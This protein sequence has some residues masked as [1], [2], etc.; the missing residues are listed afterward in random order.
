MANIAHSASTHP[1]PTVSTALPIQQTT[2]RRWDLPPRLLWALP[3]A[4][5]SLRMLPFLWTFILPAP[6]GQ[7]VLQA[8]YM[9]PDV[10]SYQAFIRQASETSSVLLSNPYT[11]DPQQGRYILLLHSSLGVCSQA[12]GIPATW[13]WELSRFPLSCLFF[14]ALWWFLKPILPERSDRIWACLLVGL[15]GGVEGLLKLVAD[16]LPE[17]FAESF[18]QAT[19]H[20]YGWNTFE[21]LANPMWIAGLTLLLV[22]LKPLLQPDGLR[23]WC[24]QCQV[25]VGFLILFY[26]HPYSGLVVLAVAGALAIT[27]AIF[28]GKLPLSKQVPIM[29]ALCVPFALITMLS[30]WQSQD[31][32]YRQ[33]AGHVFGT[34]Q[35][36]VFWY[37]FTLGF[38]GILALRGAQRWCRAEH[39]YRFALLAWLAAIIFLHSSP[40]LNGYHFVMYLHLPLC[41]LA[42]PVLRQQFHTAFTTTATESVL[43]KRSIAVG[44]LLLTFVSFALVTAEATADIRRNNLRPAEYEQIVAELSALPAGRVLAD[45]E[46]GA[47]LPTY[48]PHRVYVGHWF[49]S[50]DYLAKRDRYVTFTSD[51]KYASQ[52]EQLVDAQAVDYLLVP[53]QQ[54]SW[55]AKRFANRTTARITFRSQTLFVIEASEHSE[56]PSP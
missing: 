35:L 36:S 16:R 43:W 21:V 54:A 53:R 27:D 41:I 37:P 49:L 13:L 52:L 5:A 23:N 8:S 17:F 10:L 44:T 4:I 39:P 42:A 1:H 18:N 15:S 29:R 12:T 55:V 38:V 34:L 7:T 20:L 51:V 19:W 47:I 33:T 46:L 31:L 24:D 30:T 2:M 26:V 6:A 22:V 48:T 28:M 9:P 3:L 50:P 14:L 56:Q 40:V 45:H 11:L 25:G 32:V